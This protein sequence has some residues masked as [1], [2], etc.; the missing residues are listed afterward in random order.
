MIA[1]RVF[2]YHVR[3]ANDHAIQVTW[4]YALT[5]SWFPGTHLLAVPYFLRILSYVEWYK[6][7]VPFYVFEIRF[8]CAAWQKIFDAASLLMNLFATTFVRC[9]F[10]RGSNRPSP[11]LLLM[12]RGWCA[13]WSTSLLFCNRI[14]TI[15]LWSMSFH[16]SAGV[17]VECRTFCT[18]V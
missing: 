1:V 3:V 9:C 11:S 4:R 14:V 5:P 2:T 10:F 13:F 15:L 17:L 16:W 12:V 18:S 6:L 7:T 8:T